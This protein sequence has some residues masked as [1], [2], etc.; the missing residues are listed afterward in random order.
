MPINILELLARAKG[1][2]QKISQQNFVR[3][4]GTRLQPPRLSTRKAKER[5]SGMQVDP[6]AHLGGESGT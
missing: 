2:V 1:F 5:E 4:S 3:F 6:F